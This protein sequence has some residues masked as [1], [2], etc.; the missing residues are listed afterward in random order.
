MAVIAKTFYRS[1]LKA[2]F[3]VLKLL[4]WKNVCLSS[5]DLM[6]MRFLS[7]K[8]NGFVSQIYAISTTSFYF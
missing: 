1:I 7:E 6:E 3:G 4:F 5:A 8:V 2:T